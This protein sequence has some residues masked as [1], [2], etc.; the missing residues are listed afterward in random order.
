MPYENALLDP[1]RKEMQREKIE[2]VLETL[3]S[4]YKKGD[5][6]TMMKT[7][8]KISN[9]AARLQKKIR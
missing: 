5:S 8:E 6:D 1:R 9:F 7:H 3:R 4:L 2:Y